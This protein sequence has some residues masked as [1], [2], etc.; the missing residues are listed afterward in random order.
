MGEPPGKMVIN[1][2]KVTAARAALFGSW[3]GNWLDGL[4]H[5]PRR[6]A[7]RRHGGKV[8]FLMY[9]QAETVAGRLDCLDPDTFK[10]T[11]AR[12]EISA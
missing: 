1:D 8:A 10:Y 7:A 9:P 4:Q 2:A 12:A 3:E 6:G 5:R 11:F